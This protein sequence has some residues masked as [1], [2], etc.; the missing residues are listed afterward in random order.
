MLKLKETACEQ[1][2]AEIPHN[3]RR[4]RAFGQPHGTGLCLAVNLDDDFG[5]ARREEH[6][7]IE[8]QLVTS[9]LSQWDQVIADA[10]R[11]THRG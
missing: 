10:E 9:H 2:R 6:R 11:Q 4:L 3:P 1:L 7:R 5:R 8:V